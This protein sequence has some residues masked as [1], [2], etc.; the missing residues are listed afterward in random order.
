MGHGPPVF[1]LV[2]E[3]TLRTFG[4]VLFAT[5]TVL[6]QADEK[7]TDK[8]SAERSVGVI[9]HALAH[10][11]KRVV[12]IEMLGGGRA[13]HI[14]E[15]GLAL[16][17]GLS[18]AAMLQRVGRVSANAAVHPQGEGREPGVAKVGSGGA[19]SGKLYD[20]LSRKHGKLSRFPTSREV[21]A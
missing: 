21:Q 10:Q 18:R 19:Q 11:R 12:L 16:A 9:A 7:T 14:V 13:E 3:Q 6:R 1:C 15:G 4:G 8:G 5:L 17:F 2:L 20:V